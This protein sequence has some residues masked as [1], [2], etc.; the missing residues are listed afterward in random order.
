MQHSV[1]DAMQQ[2][3][4]QIK[5][6]FWHFNPAFVYLLLFIYFSCVM[7]HHMQNNTYTMTVQM[8]LVWSANLHPLTPSAHCCAMVS[9]SQWAT[10]TDPPRVYTMEI[11]CD[12]DWSTTCL[13]HGD[14]VWLVHGT[15]IDCSHKQETVL[16]YEGSNH[17]SIAATNRKLFLLQSL[18]YCSHKQETVFERA[19]ITSVLQPQ[20]GNCFWKGLQSLQYCS[21]KQETVFERAPITSVLQPQTGLAV[22]ERGHL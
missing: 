17:F 22:F 14:H 13:H 15:N 19:P 1:T 11:M 3:L 9:V 16:N 10:V 7:Y 4:K 5:E 18:Q 2:N 21:H 12:G 20:A 8:I 6:T